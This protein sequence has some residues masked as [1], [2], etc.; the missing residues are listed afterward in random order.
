M[1]GLLF[2]SPHLA[3]SLIRSIVMRDMCNVGLWPITPVSAVQRYVR[4]SG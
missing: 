3:V 2:G 4:S 1:R